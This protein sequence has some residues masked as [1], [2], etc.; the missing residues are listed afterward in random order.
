MISS[1]NLV[2]LVKTI[3]KKEMSLDEAEL[4]LSD[5]FNKET[6]KLIHLAIITENNSSLTQVVRY[7]LVNKDF[8][9]NDHYYQLCKRALALDGMALRY[10]DEAYAGDMDFYLGAVQQNGLA[11]EYV[12]KNIAINNYFK[13]ALEAVQENPT[14]VSLVRR[15]LPEQ[16]RR[17]IFLK[18]V[19]IDGL[20]LEYI[21]EMNN[22][23]ELGMTAVE[24]NIYAMEF[25]DEDL[26]HLMI[27][28]GKAEYFLE[29][30]Y[31]SHLYFPPIE[32]AKVGLFLERIEHVI[33]FDKRDLEDKELEDSRSVYAMSDSRKGK[34]T[35]VSTIDIESLLNDLQTLH[36]KTNKKI[37][38][39]ILGHTN[40]RC[41]KIA[42]LTASDI[43]SLLH[44][45]PVIGKLT[46]FGCK[47]L[48]SYKLEEEKA[49]IKRV[50]SN[51][52]IRHCGLLVTR[53]DDIKDPEKLLR[54]I[55]L[56]EA[57]V[58]TESKL[59][60]SSIYS[61]RYIKKLGNE[62]VVSNSSTLSQDE[63]KKLENKFCKNKSI[64]SGLI[65]KNT[66]CVLKN[67]NTPL[68]MT[69]LEFFNQFFSGDKFNNQN[70]LY[71]ESKRDYPFLRSMTIDLME[72]KQKFTESLMQKIIME[73]EK[74]PRE[75]QII[76]KGYGNIIHVDNAE[77]R[78]HVLPDLCYTKHF[79]QHRL[80]NNPSIDNLNRKQINTERRK[81]IDE[82]ESGNEEGDTLAKSIKVV[83]G[84]KSI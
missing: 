5:L 48:Q 64:S 28:S 27:S 77:K 79:Y 41:E 84:G 6:I 74:N 63:I 23:L 68:Q 58:I 11:L 4:R 55:K 12:P 61:I 32:K 18:A 36:D 17:A 57:Y 75:H 65:N 83:I 16:Y 21:F 42:G 2:H 49:I 34:V 35:S 71:Q 69:E 54:S 38:L 70:A 7:S 47:G 56:N 25:V 73:I 26:R 19:T 14:A 1:T 59:E 3:V 31:M 20:A 50:S 45:Y 10:V 24:Q 29:K 66:M 52:S 37:N 30:N 76:V 60:D 40:V 81:M 43:N 67:A 44:K 72:C 80:F 46:L 82:I 9:N 13:I 22:D 15:G 62:V 8:E 39:L 51:K 78:F 53:H 33:V